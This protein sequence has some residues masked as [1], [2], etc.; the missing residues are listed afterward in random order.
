MPVSANTEP[1][2][3]Q[4]SLEF[5]R[6]FLPLLPFWPHS[7]FSLQ[8]FIVLTKAFSCFI[9]HFW[10]FSATIFPKTEVGR[11]SHAIWLCISHLP[12]QERHLAAALGLGSMQSLLVSLDHGLSSISESATI[13][14]LRVL[15][16]RW[17]GQGKTLLLG[18]EAT[19]ECPFPEELDS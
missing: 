13:R 1:E 14:P 18:L 16:C 10:L 3:L 4:L 5:P 11:S 7:F 12:S 2:G 19:G 15:N 8:I 9:Q 6:G 17:F